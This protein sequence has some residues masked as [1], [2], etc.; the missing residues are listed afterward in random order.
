L[1]D[2]CHGQ[3]IQSERVSL[4][5]LVF[6]YV[7][8]DLAVYMEKCP[9]PGLPITKVKSIMYQLLDG[10]DFLHTNR[11]FHRD[12]KPQ[13]VLI[14]HQGHVKIAD[15]GLTRIF[16]MQSVLTQVVVTLWYRAPEILMSSKYTS[17]VDIWSC[18]CIFAEMIRNRPLFAGHTETD[19]LCKIFEITGTPSLGEWPEDISIPIGAFPRFAGSQLRKLLEAE[20]DSFGLALIEEMLLFIPENRILAKDALVHPYFS[21]IAKSPSQVDR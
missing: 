1:L 21:D 20:L 13:N 4:L 11:L 7:E 2:V 8:Q 17:A 16:D 10:I 12:L 15:F 18:G 5:Y 9:P 6:E 19:Q 3:K 14:D